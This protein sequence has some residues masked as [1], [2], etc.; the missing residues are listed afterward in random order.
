A[1][2]TRN[3]GVFQCSILV[4]SSA[5]TPAGTYRVAVGPSDLRGNYQYYNP[6]A[7]AA[8]GFDSTLEIQP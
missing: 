5:S 7:L 4:R 8:Q 2:G 6:A 3:D 1:S